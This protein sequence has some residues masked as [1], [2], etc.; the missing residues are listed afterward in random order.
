MYLAEWAFLWLHIHWLCQKL[1]ANYVIKYGNKNTLSHD[2][3]AV[4]WCTDIAFFYRLSLR[5]IKFY[6]PIVWT[7]KIPLTITNY[8]S[9]SIIFILVV[10]DPTCTTN[11]LMLGRMR[12]IV[13]C[14]V[15]VLMYVSLSWTALKIL[16][17]DVLPQSIHALPIL[18]IAL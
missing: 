6:F 8:I 12:T 15:L 9:P 2:T 14:S 11:Y 4:S 13:N 10:Y 17:W 1:T 16:L 18:L 3:I 7:Q 5:R